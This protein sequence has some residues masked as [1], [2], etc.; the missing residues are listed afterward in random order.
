MTNRLQRAAKE[1][2][3]S[4]GSKL[5]ETKWPGGTSI[6]AQFGS[7]NRSYVN[8]FVRGLPA[9]PSWRISSTVLGPCAITQSVAMQWP[10]AND[11]DWIPPPAVTINVNLRNYVFPV[12]VMLLKVCRSAAVMACM[13][14]RAALACPIQKFA[15]PTVITRL[16]S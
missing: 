12:R 11:S 5:T 1:N 13:A 6:D 15:S 4:R 2:P 3:G 9:P 7:P 16:G 10:V 14:I 8:Q